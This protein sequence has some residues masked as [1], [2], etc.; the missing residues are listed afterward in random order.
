MRKADSFAVAAAPVLLVIAM[1]GG[2]IAADR[3]GHYTG[4]EVVD[5]KYDPAIAAELNKDNCTRF[6]PR[7]DKAVFEVSC[8]PSNVTPDNIVYTQPEQFGWRPSFDY[9]PK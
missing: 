2:M 8:D 6:K 3:A 5:H 1:V 4:I 9:L 7:D